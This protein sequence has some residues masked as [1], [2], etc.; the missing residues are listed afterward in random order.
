[1]TTVFHEGETVLQI[2]SGVEAR[3]HEFGHKLIRDYRK[4]NNK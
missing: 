2:E 3:M 1:M 4:Q